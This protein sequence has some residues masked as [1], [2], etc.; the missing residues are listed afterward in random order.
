MNFCLAGGSISW[1]EVNIKIKKEDPFLAAYI[2]K[3]FDI[4]Q[5]GDAIRIGRDNKGNS[6]VSGLE[7][8]T[9]IPPYNFYAKPKNSTSDY[10]LYITLQPSDLD[11]NKIHS[12][13]ITIRKKLSSD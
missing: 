11:N 5:I 9:R 10:T 7:V 3:S 13:Q 12:W 2:I 8:G 1:D 4:A 6:T